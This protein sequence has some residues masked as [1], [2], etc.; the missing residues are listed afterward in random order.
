M[1]RF[2]LQH[3]LP[4]MDDGKTARQQSRFQHEYGEK[5]LSVFP[6]ML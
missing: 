1:R 3:R 5:T 4:D 2:P 6:H